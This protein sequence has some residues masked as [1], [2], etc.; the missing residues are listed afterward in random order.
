MNE[1]ISVPVSLVSLSAAIASRADNL[2]PDSP[3]D[4]LLAIIRLTER[5]EGLL[6]RLAIEF[7]PDS[8]TTVAA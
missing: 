7:K 4:D 8:I 5:L 3:A 6:D 1:T 2:T